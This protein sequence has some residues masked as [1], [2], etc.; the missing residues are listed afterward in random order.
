MRAGTRRHAV[1]R[2][3]AHP[4]ATPPRD[5]VALRFGPATE[6]PA[7]DLYRP[8]NAPGAAAT[9]T[10]KPSSRRRDGFGGVPARRA[11]ARRPL[12]EADRAVRAVSM[13]W[14]APSASVSVRP[15]IPQRRGL[16]SG[17]R[18]QNGRAGAIRRGLNMD[19]IK[20]GLSYCARAFP[21][22]S[23]PANNRRGSDQERS[24]AEVLDLIRANDQRA[25]A[26]PRPNCRPASRC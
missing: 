10:P 18:R 7:P 4:S 14:P 1:H 9:S 17:H 21:T 3:V 12:G 19:R 23:A 6:A 13:M 20:R 22:P 8:D 15:R 16:L 25:P 24:R 2:A 5:S 11:P 26:R